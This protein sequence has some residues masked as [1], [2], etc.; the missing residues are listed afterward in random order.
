MSRNLL[1]YLIN[2]NMSEIWAKV[3]ILPSQDPQP[4]GQ[5]LNPVD[6]QVHPLKRVPTKTATEPPHKFCQIMG[7]S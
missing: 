3:K 2:G 4:Q 1:L 7:V 6:F 5:S